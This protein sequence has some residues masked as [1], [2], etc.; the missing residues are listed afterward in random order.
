MCHVLDRCS[1]GNPQQNFSYLWGSC[2]QTTVIDPDVGMFCCPCIH[3]Y[4]YII[5]LSKYIYIYWYIFLFIFVFIL[6]FM[7]TQK[8]KLK[9]L[10]LMFALSERGE[11]GDCRH[12]ETSDGEGGDRFFPV[13]SFCFFRQGCFL[14]QVLYWSRRNANK[15]WTKVWANMESTQS[16]VISG[17]RT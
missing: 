15:V 1:S 12:R 4:I 5:I 10:S 11:I 13:S 17:H 2:I 6:I 9:I 14:A 16:I 3:I 8:K 7:Y